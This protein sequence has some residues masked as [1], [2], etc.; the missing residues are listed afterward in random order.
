[1]PTQE[2][3]D[4]NESN[5]ETSEMENYDDASESLGGELLNT[6]EKWERLAAWLPAFNGA[7]PLMLHAWFQ[8]IEDLTIA[9]NGGTRVRVLLARRRLEGEAKDIMASVITSDYDCFKEM[10]LQVYKPEVAYACLQ[11]ELQAKTRYTGCPSI[12]IALHEARTDFYAV[13]EYTGI[14]RLELATQILHAVA[15]LIPDTARAIAH[16]QYQGDFLEQLDKLEEQLTSAIIEGSTE[17]WTADNRTTQAYA[18][19]ASPI[20]PQTTTPATY[21]RRGRGRGKGKP[22]PDSTSQDF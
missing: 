5:A 19:E 15:I 17:S 3:V 7:A 20:V 22:Q 9:I 6:P 10:L 8:E 2:P 21:R 16:I 4:N 14:E 1:M 11:A 18:V 12:R 13:Q